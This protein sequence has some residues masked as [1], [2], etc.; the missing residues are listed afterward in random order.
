M[1]KSKLT[2]ERLPMRTNYFKKMVMLLATSCVAASAF[3]QYVW[4]D[5]HGVKQFSDIAPPG[6]VSQDRILKQPRHASGHEPTAATPAD[7]GAADGSAAGKA[8]ATTAEKNA[9]YNKRRLE[10]AEKDKKTE[11]EAKRKLVKADD[12]ARAT[13]YLG[14][15]K[16]GIRIAKTE[17]NGERSYL[18]DADRAKEEA[19]A[20]SAVDSCK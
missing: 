3:A 12:C 2:F 1:A 6:N 18:T 9:D 11:E 5:E 14:S 10:Q 7:A 20:Q 13:S 17:S 4:L 15:L 16:S 19:Q 8:P